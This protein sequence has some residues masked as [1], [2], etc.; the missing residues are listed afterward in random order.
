[1]CIDSCTHIQIMS[2][3]IRKTC[4]HDP[5]PYIIYI[6]IYAYVGD[7]CDASDSRIREDSSRRKSPCCCPQHTQPRRFVS[8]S[9]HLSHNARRNQM[10]CDAKAHTTPWGTTS[11]HWLHLSLYIYRY[12]CIYIYIYVYVC[13]YIHLYTY[14]YTYTYTYTHYIY[15]YTFI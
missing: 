14:G 15:I 9:N 12:T 11:K 2:G 13:M 6:Y 7:E 10:I 5:G 3:T 4:L 1:M 8:A